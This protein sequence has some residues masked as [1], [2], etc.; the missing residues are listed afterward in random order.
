M[1]KKAWCCFVAVAC[2]LAGALAHAQG[3][4]FPNRP[5]RLVVPSSPGG[6]IDVVTRLL[7]Q[8][9][10][11]V[12][13]QSVVI[14]NRPG[15]STNIGTEIVARA[16]GNGYTLLTNTL[17]LV[18]NPSLFQKLPFDVEKDFAPVSLLVGAPYVLSAHLSVPVKSVKELVALAKA[19]PGVLNY[20]SGGDGTNLHVAMELFRNMT[21]AQIVHLPYKGGGPA[22]AS[23]VRGE[24]DL[25]MLSLVAVLPHVN[26]GRV[27]ALAIT[28]RRRTA[29]LPEV[30]T[31]AESGVAGYEFTSG[32]GV[33]APAS[34]PPAIIASL[35]GYVV[36]AMQ[37]PDL[38]KRFANEGTHVIASSPGQFGAHLKTEIARWAK[39]VKEARIKLE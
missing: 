2:A 11:E 35:N 7:G 20:A 6:I 36:K 31:I 12:M 28:D 38:S 32:V 9:L 13:G 30:P 4:D 33:L 18:V 14:E 16:P 29:M 5:V 22:L 37:A 17:P 8:K 27:R 26:A 10:S 1:Q 3:R 21:G 23:L 34:T 39:V 15:A 24:S 19:R 25:S